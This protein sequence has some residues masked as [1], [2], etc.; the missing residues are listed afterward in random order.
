[1]KTIYQNVSRFFFYINPNH[2]STF[3]VCHSFQSCDKNFLRTNRKWIRRKNEKK[4]MKMKT[5]INQSQKLHKSKFVVLLWKINIKTTRIKTKSQSFNVAV[6]HQFSF[7]ML[8]VH[9]WLNKPCIFFS[10]FFFFFIFIVSFE[11]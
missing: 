1:M 6:S 4:K 5:K 7:D 11:S 2:A 9:C 3:S 8:R 10:I